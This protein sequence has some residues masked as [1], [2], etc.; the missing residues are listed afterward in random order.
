M[1]CQAELLARPDEPLCR[2]ILVPLDGIAVVHG[3]LV[4]EVVV[5]FTNGDEGSNK[6]VT[7]TV[8]VIEWRFTK[9]VSER[10]NAERRLEARLM[11]YW[12]QSKKRTW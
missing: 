8:F 9:P 12:S 2:V 7:R 4:V 10:V 1:A 11:T 6:V 3:E 5:P